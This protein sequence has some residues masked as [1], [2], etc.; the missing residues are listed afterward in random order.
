[1]TK[2]QE[3]LNYIEGLEIGKTVSTRGIANRMHVADG[4]AYK[5]I[6]EAENR[7]LVAVNDRSGTVRVAAKGQKALYRLTF[8]KLVEL[9]DAE[10]LGGLAG[11]EVEFEH[12]VISAMQAKSFKKYLKGNGLVIVGDRTDIQTAAL[13]AHNAVLITGGLAV[14]QAVI[15]YADS[16]GIPLMRT[17]YDTFTV[18]NRISHALTN[19]LIKKDI[20]T[21]A[22]ILHQNRPK[23]KETQTV[24]DF[25]ELFNSTGFSRF[26]VVD[27]Q[28]RVVGVVAMRDVNAKGNTTPLKTLM[29]RANV[30]KLEMPVVSVSQIMIY[31]GY[32]MMP[33]V[34]D[35][36]VYNGVI[37][38]SDVLQSMQRSQ[39]ESMVSHTFTDNIAD[40][41][42]EQGSSFQ[43]IVEP[44]MINSVGSVSTGIFTELAGLVTRRVMAKR[45]HRTVIMESMNIN[46]MR[47]AGIDSV[48]D[49]Y[50]KMI[51]ETRLAAMIDVEIYHVN[52]IVAKI[53]VNVN[54]T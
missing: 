22:D 7:G 1:M 10:V 4:T 32:D 18:A 16:L 8:G 15:D 39:E 54:L 44:F 11:L 5:A 28:N 3:I 38:K 6:K 35:K 49:I 29:K 17:N 31:E 47:T 53:L 46:L 2:H 43:V 21:V 51:S 14:S 36:Q 23:L 37:T 30:A 41:I 19:E 20:V 9:A 50:P 34:D 45:R 48:L 52:Q 25:L 33:V 12:F 24:K 27:S 42:K 13:Q 26:P 40:K